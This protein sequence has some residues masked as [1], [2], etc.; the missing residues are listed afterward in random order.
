MGRGGG[1]AEGV[2]KPEALGGCL[3]T[4]SPS[5]VL[6]LQGLPSL[7]LSLLPGGQVSISEPP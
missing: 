4:S 2:G 5:G 1:A 7:P 3:E 6:P